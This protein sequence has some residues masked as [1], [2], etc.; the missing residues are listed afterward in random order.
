MPDGGTT[1]LPTTS[2]L[3]TPWKL[4][5]EQA[6][7]TWPDAAARRIAM[8]PNRPYFVKQDILT[9]IPRT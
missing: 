5:F 8:V 3:K 1:K 9:S 4:L 6:A 7:W 2:A